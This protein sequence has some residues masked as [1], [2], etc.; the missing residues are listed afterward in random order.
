MKPGDIVAQGDILIEMVSTKPT[1]RPGTTI[2]P[3]DPDGAVVLARGEVTGH[4]HAIWNNAVMFRDEAASSEIGG[5]YVGS[6]AVKE[7]ADLVH[8]EHDK[9]ALPEGTYNIRRQRSAEPDTSARMI[10]D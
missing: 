7:G 10:A 6:L 4:R 2:I 5:L 3:N 9:I 8:E 1:P